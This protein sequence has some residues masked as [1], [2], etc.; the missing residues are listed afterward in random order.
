MSPEG[1]I[2]RLVGSLGVG[3]KVLDTKRSPDIDD[4]VRQPEALPY[5]DPASQRYLGDVQAIDRDIDECLEQPR[6][7]DQY[8]INDL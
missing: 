6:Y 8:K 3:F 1:G 4:M 7:A 2:P 5:H